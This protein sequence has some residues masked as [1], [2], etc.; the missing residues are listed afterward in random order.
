[1][2]DSYEG[3]EG[4]AHGQDHARLRRAVPVRP[5]RQGRV[6][7]RVQGDVPAAGMTADL[8]LPE[9]GAKVEP[10]GRR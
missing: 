10:R 3:D 4:S 8:V 6:I 9:G 5:A 1:M 2:R 7:G